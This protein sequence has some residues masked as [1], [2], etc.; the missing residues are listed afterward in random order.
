MLKIIYT[1]SFMTAGTDMLR[2]SLAIL[3]RCRRR[4]RN[5]GNRL[6]ISLLLVWLSSLLPSNTPLAIMWP[7]NI[8]TIHTVLHH[9]SDDIIIYTV[10]ITTM[11]QYYITTTMTS[12]YIQYY[13]TTVMAYTVLH[14]YND[15]IIIHTVLRWRHYNTFYD[16]FY[17]CKINT[18][19]LPEMYARVQPKDCRH[20][21]QAN[22]KCPQCSF[23]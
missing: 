23:R 8:Y 10:Y 12:Q 6:I 14:Y 19:D 9:Y 3:V 20:T 11:I 16:T 4:R 22:H 15:D 2:W 5:V 13:I 21:F 1:M 17:S 18:S 7:R